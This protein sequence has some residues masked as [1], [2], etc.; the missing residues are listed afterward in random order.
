MRVQQ[1]ARKTEK[2]DKKAS[3]YES[4]FVP[5]IFLWEPPN[6][7]KEKPN[8]WGGKI[9]GVD[10]LAIDSWNAFSGKGIDWRIL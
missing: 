10:R 4:F 1:D 9:V 2:R 8:E 7:R 6:E 3:S 5:E